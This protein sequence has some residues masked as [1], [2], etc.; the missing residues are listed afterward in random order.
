MYC[1]PMVEAGRIYAAM[2]P[3]YGLETGKG[4]YQYFVDDR[5]LV[6]YVHK[7]FSKN[8]TIS[9]LKGRVLTDLEIIDM[10]CKNANLVYYMNMA[11]TFAV[12]P[13]LLEL[14]LVNRNKDDIIAFL[15]L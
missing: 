13:Y 2:P 4:K 7:Q 9:T 11:T 6:D 8:Y 3:L 5:A 14:V 1:R 10:L 12:D 15:I